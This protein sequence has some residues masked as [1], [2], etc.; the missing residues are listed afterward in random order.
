M[1]EEKEYTIKGMKTRLDELSINDFIELC[2]GDLSVLGGQIVHRAR[3]T[4]ATGSVEL[5][6]GDKDTE[7][8]KALL[9]SERKETAALLKADFRRIADP[10]GY[11]SGV[12]KAEG[13]TRERMIIGFF[14]VLSNLCL[15]S[16]FDDVRELYRQSG[17]N[18][19]GMDDQALEQAIKNEQA[20]AEFELK[21]RVEKE[22]V[23]EP[24][25]ED[26]SPERMAM[27]IRESFGTEVAGLNCYLRM[28]VD[29]DRTNAFVYA[30]MLRQAREEARVRREMAMKIGRKGY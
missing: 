23:K 2:V 28:S 13:E 18:P 27:R 12:A 25:K 22:K 10:A 16:A 17:R 15:L 19:D 29:M 1:T 26:E 4:A 11:K 20:R 30:S 24:E 7:A 21:R 14:R 5:T 3:E 8:D 6:D 9:E